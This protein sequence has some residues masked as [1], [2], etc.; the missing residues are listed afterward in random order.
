MERDARDLQSSK[1]RNS[2]SMG[3]IYEM[4]RDMT[5]SNNNSLPN[6][7]EHLLN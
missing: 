7:D 6:I 5:S 2:E 3:R 4:L 1:K